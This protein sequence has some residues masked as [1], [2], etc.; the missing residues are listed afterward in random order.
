MG[1]ELAMHDD[2]NLLAN[3]CNFGKRWFKV[4]KTMAM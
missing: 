3:G 1:F 4:C 2:E